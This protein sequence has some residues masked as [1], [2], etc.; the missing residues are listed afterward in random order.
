MTRTSIRPELQALLA[1]LSAAN[2]PHNGLGAALTEDG[3]YEVFTYSETG[4]IIP[5]PPE[6]APIV[7]AHVPPD[8]ETPPTDILLAL[9]AD[10]TD[11]D[12]TKPILEAMLMILGGQL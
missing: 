3:D 8:P 11:V 12:E 10:V 5:L 2:V 9:L 7:A 6:A 1:E 4:E